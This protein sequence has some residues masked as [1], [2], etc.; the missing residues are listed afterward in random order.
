MPVLLVWPLGVL[1]L[2]AAVRW[3][4][5]A[6]RYFL[7]MAL[8]PQRGVGDLLPLWY[9]IETRRELLILNGLSWL[10]LGAVAVANQHGLAT[11][12]IRAATLVIV[13]LPLLLMLLRRERGASRSR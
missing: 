2:V 12:A 10:M 7:L 3:R 6:A 4:Q 5:P 1:L 9:L 13:Y 11:A 8:V